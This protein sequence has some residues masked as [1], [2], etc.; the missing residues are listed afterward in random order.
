M[1]CVVLNEREK[2]GEWARARIPHV[3]SWG[4]WYQCIGLEEDGKPIAAVVFNLFSGCD[5]AMHVAA[6]GKRW[7]SREYLRTCFAYPFIQLGCRRVTAYVSSRNETAWQF[8]RH[9]GFQQ[10]GLMREAVPDDDVMVY[11]MLKNECRWIQ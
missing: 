4:E 8:V 9:L 6:E 11:G 1:K 5:I 10:E 2:F 7:M 3:P